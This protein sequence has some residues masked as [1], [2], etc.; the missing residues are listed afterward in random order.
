MLSINGLELSPLRPYIEA[1]NKYL[2]PNS[3]LSVSLYNGPRNFVVTGPPRALYGLVT[4]LRK[5]QAPS[6]QDQSKDPYSQRKPAFGVRFLVVNAPYHS[7]YLAGATDKLYDE[8]LGGKEL[9]SSDELK[10][11]VF[12]TADGEY[13]HVSSSTPAEQL[14]RL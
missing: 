8:D 6:S 13:M 12:N 10:I 2:P 11:P 1:T 4:N 3:Q 9:W 14:R 5:V 7:T